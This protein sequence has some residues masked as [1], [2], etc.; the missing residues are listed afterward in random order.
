MA[1]SIQHLVL[2]H[3]PRQL[4]EDEELEM[5]AQVQRWPEAIGGFSRLRFGRDVS[6]RSR[7]YDYALLIEFG[8][9][10]AAERY[11]PHPAH[12]AFADWVHARGS[13]EI[14]VDYDVRSS[15]VVGE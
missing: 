15:A 10:E 7:G 13:E 5:F 9:Q 6:G 11:F 1:E 2:F 3:F 8:N 14:V 12:R 4:T